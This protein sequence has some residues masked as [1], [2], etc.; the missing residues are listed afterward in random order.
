MSSS[1]GGKLKYLR[2]SRGLVQQEVAD[3]LE[4]KRSTYSNYEGNRRTPSMNEMQKFA[5]FY[6]V[7]L[8]YF[9][10]VASSD[11]ILEIVSRARD[12]FASKDVPQERKEELH[13]ELMRLYLNM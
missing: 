2:K 11:E 12:V 4:M 10:V 3:R 9:G 7:T 1:L 13:K 6:G 5:A 8:D